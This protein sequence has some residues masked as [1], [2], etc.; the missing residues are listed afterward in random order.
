MIFCIVD[1]DL[2]TFSLS[3]YLVKNQLYLYRRNQRPGPKHGG[4]IAEPTY[5]NFPSA[6]QK[7]RQRDRNAGGVSLG[8]ATKFNGTDE[9][10]DPDHIYQN[11]AR[12]RGSSVDRHRKI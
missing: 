8:G 9:I 5:A 10:D 11:P 7:K 1:Y 4:P 12:I 2:Q 6:M 3:Y